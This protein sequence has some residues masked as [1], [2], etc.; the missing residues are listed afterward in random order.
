MIPDFATKMLPLNNMRN[1]DFSWGKMQQKAFEDIK[2]ELCANPLVQPYSLQ[3]E[4]TVTTDASEKVIGGVLSQEGHPVIYVSRKLTPAEQNYSNIEREALAIVF[5]ITGLKQFLLGRRFTLQTDHKPLKYLFAP[6]QEIPKTASARIT[7]WAIALM[8]FDYEL[9][10]TPG[11]QIPHADALSR[12]DFDEDESDND[13]VCFAINNIYFAQSDLVTQAEIKTELGTNRLFQDIMKRI[14]SGNWKQCSEAEKG[15]EQQKDALTIHNGIIFRGVVPFIPP[16]LRH[17]VL[18]KAHETHPGKNATEASVRM[19]AWWPGITQDVQHFVSKCKN[20]QLNRP[21]LG[22]TV[23]TWPEADVWERLHMD[24]GY[25]KDQGNIL[26]IVDAGSGWIEAF[27]AGNRTS[28]TVKIYLSQIFA[29][30]GI[31]KTLVSDNGPESVSGD[32]KQWC[33]SLGI[34][35]LE[36]PVYHPRANGLAERAVQTVKRA[37][38]AWSPNLNVS[39]GAFLQR[40]LMTHRNTSK[41]R[42]KT[43]VELLLGRRVR[44]PAIADFDLCE[45][46]LFKANE[47]T[48]TVPA[49]FIIRKGLN[50]SFIQPENSARTILVS[51]NQI[52]RLDEDNVKTE[53][54]VEETISQSKLQPQNTD[55]GPSHQDEASA[56]TSSAEHQQPETSEP[57]RTST[58]NRKQPDRFG[59]PI[60]TNLLKKGGRM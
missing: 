14:K 49:T 33:E 9:K 28:E 4:A 36:S 27:P 58:R 40:A 24:W 10:Y 3:K 37:L 26:V 21:S 47:N 53:P 32:L 43:P 15:F 46:I 22:K 20:C 11:E 41:T 56:A 13:R 17:L 29:R 31:P 51:D 39:F 12:M 52:A 19:I 34:K 59:E 55:V 6:D 25:V 38:Q 16:K 44:L 7:R 54:A 30:F 23:S 45:P 42:S 35:K 1:S 57:S 8:G 50:T 5:V 60:P 48:K 18:A 2:N